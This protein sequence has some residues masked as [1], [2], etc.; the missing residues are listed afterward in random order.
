[1]EN[2]FLKSFHVAGFSYYQGALLFGEMSIGSRIEIVAD[3]NNKYDE[4]AIE[5]RFKGHK[6]GHIPKSENQEISKIINSG[7]DIFEA[8]VQQLSPEEHP[9]RQV[10]VAIFV[11]SSKK[12]LKGKNFK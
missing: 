4:H 5:L 8:V 6:I 7:Y 11:I 1:M 2:L 3:K 12:W 10:R 9:E